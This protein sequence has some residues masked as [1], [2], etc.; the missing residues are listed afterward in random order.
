MIEE[1]AAKLGYDPED[2][3]PEEVYNA[4][5]NNNSAI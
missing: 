3:I 2:K 1:E 4:P 5:K